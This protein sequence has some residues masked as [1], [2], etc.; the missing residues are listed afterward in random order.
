AEIMA[1]TDGD[2]PAVA[3]PF[4]G[5]GS[6]PLEAQRLGLR[7]YASDLNPVAVLITKA[8]I[9][10]P[11]LFA[12]KPPVHP[13]EGTMAT[14][15]AWNGA[16]GLAADVRYYGEWM[17]E[18]ALE[19][20]GHL[21]PKATLPDGSEATVIAWLW[22]RTITCPN[23]ACSFQMP[24]MHSFDLSK[25]KGNE[26]H[27]NPVVDA[28][29]RRIRFDIAP[30]P[31]TRE[32]TV[33]RNGAQ[34]L[35]CSQPVEMK[36]VRSEAH[37]GRMGSQL[38]A[39]VA[40]GTRRRVY[41][42][43]DEVHEKVAESPEPR[44]APDGEMPT[45]PRWFSPPGFG[46][47]TWA[48]LFTPRQ[49]TALTTFSDL[50]AEARNQAYADARGAGLPDDSIPLRDHGTG[51]KAY[52]EA[53]SLYLAL[54]V[55]RLAMTG[56]HLVRWNPV[57]EKAQ[58][59]FG[60]QAIPMVWDFGEVNFFGSA[61]GSSAAAVEATN[62]SI[63]HAGGAPAEAQVADAR[64][65]RLPESCLILT[66]PPYF[67]NIGYA[68][69]ADFFY[70]WLR[71][72]LAS[73]FPVETATVATPKSAELVATP[74]R[75]GGSKHAA[76][77][78]FEEGFLRAFSAIREDT[79]RRYP[80]TLFY[81]YKQSETVG[82]GGRVSTGWETMLESL[83]AAGFRIV[84]T[85][86]MRTEKGSRMNALEANSLA[87]SIVLVCYV[88]PL[89]AGVESRQNFM[90]RLR[91]EMPT[92]IA[93]LRHAALPPVDLGQAAIGPGMAIYSSYQK[94]LEPNG[95]RMPVRIALGLINQVLDELIA[96]FDSEVDEPTRFLV[97]WY[98][99]HG[100]STGKFDDANKL[101]VQKATA[102]AALRD[103]GL[104]ESR[105]G[106]VRLRRRDELDPD[107]DP[108][109]D[110]RLT[111][112]EACMYLLRRLEDPSG[113]V[114]AAGALARSLGGV[115]ETAR[116]LA[117]R[118]YQIATNT[119][120]TEDALAFNALVVEWPDIVAAAEREPSGQGT[121]G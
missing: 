5:G 85:W 65:L 103:E 119:G 104:L 24:L 71:R 90:R 86:P 96:E 112:W 55:D 15:G 56:T 49:L 93:E 62:D 2:P 84:G 91:A 69:L 57:G 81:A 46:M 72:S 16:A 21:Y 88:R 80:L 52:A 92:A 20:I 6:I 102:V 108:S 106:S 45:N 9:E 42:P 25:K 77:A 63:R 3:D 61:T 13:R 22:A 83:M 32:R 67:D 89:E 18:R 75:F 44:W 101:A 43:A 50:T 36:Y 118:L 34:C 100:Y 10:I 48:S 33:G 109:T 47:T 7:A 115:A 107:W 74:Y 120:R 12:G 37:R 99:Q 53:I 110:R 39:I 94:V 98:E 54:M 105:G 117:Y 70:A 1:A 87:S 116:D 76:G 17:R 19:R 28:V 41:L 35:A 121:L 95:Q 68:D 114:A 30:G 23:P 59:M 51:A 58:H 73:V 40:E 11:P 60:R 79:D 31:S 97:A 26:R 14:P 8:L 113:G 78:H 82:E 111:H 66:D 38:T 64:H 29:A 27:L 4:C